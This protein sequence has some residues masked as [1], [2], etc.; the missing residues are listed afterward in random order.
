MSELFGGGGLSCVRHICEILPMKSA[1]KIKTR[2]RLFKPVALMVIAI[3]VVTGFQLY[4]LKNNYDREK[5]NLEVITSSLFHR[6]VLDQQSSK[7]KLETINMWFDSTTKPTRMEI[8]RQKP[9]K[10]VKFN[11]PVALPREPSITL[12]F[13]ILE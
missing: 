11:R 5:E 1:D 7:L 10:K 2:K 6:T 4:W 9:G 3:I 8:G 12:V 13:L